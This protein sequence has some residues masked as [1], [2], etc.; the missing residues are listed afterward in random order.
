VVRIFLVDDHASSREPLAFMLNREADLSVVAEAGSLEEARALL[1]V[2]SHGIEVMVLDLGLPDGSGEELIPDLRAAQPDASTLVLTYFSD[3]DRLARAVEAGAT[4]I[5]H[6]S[7]P[8]G[9]VVDAV[10]RLHAGEQILSVEHVLAALDIAH[11][12]RDQVESGPDALTERELDVLQALAEGLSDRDI[13]DRFH[14][15]P[16]TVRSHITAI[17]GKLGATSRLHALVIAVRR[18]IVTIT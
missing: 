7:A 15:G 8:V 5:L 2:G 4:G 14:V 9:E 13:A 6:K 1:T 17:L 11:N 10:R 3:R 18:S 16:A 12:S